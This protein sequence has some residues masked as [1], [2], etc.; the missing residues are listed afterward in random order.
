MVWA[1]TSKIGCGSTSWREGRFIKQFL[2]CNYG[3]AGNTLRRPIYDV[4]KACSRCPT[5]TTCSNGLCS[6][7]GGAASFPVV[8]RPTNRPLPIPTRRPVRPI[9]S[10]TPPRVEFGFLPMTHNLQDPR[11]V[12]RPVLA[13]E[14]EQFNNA[15]SVQNLL[16]PVPN[17]LPN[18]PPPS[19]L[20]QGSP[21]R[22]PR[23]VATR[24][25]PLGAQ[26]RPNNCKG[27]FAF[28]C[29]LLG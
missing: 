5:G 16:Q 28:M 4:G 6:S 17:V 13:T 21:I 24:P 23:P 10:Q 20:L 18:P 9:I 12:Q 1:Q 14:A 22:V 2:V 3:P 7:N 8:P 26:R 25:R 11:P 15:I 29:S 19:F 27:M